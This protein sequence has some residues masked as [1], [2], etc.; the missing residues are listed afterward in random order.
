MTEQ[1]AKDFL[2]GYDD[3]LYKA[4]DKQMLT[5]QLRWSIEYEQVVKSKAGGKFYLLSWSKPA[6]EMQYT[7]GLPEVH[8]ERVYPHQ[9]LHTV[10]KATP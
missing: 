3:T 9:E 8:I 6:T 1:E 5:A 2:F 4:A 10:W 7:E